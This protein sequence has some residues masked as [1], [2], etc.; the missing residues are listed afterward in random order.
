[1][2]DS[3]QP[4]FALNWH[5]HVSKNIF[6]HVWH[7]QCQN[8]NLPAH[9]NVCSFDDSSNMG[10]FILT[11]YRFCLQTMTNGLALWDLLTNKR[12]DRNCKTS[13]VK[14]Q[15]HLHVL[16]HTEKMTLKCSHVVNNTKVLWQIANIILSVFFIF[17]NNIFKI[18]ELVQ[19]FYV[20]WISFETGQ[21][22]PHLHAIN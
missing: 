22:G 4:S 13:L 20:G 11:N 6:L 10:C 5:R 16:T 3:N 8:C 15:F 9:S 17:C 18:D 21:K 1:M 2:Y 12:K 14:Y 7:I 19:I